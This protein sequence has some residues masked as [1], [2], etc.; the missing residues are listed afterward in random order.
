MHP[1][2]LLY[3]SVDIYRTAGH[4]I[5][6]TTGHRRFVFPIGIQIDARRDD[7]ERDEYDDEGFEIHGSA[8]FFNRFL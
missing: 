2:S 3:V 7:D 4:C 6:V 1:P 8:Y 5:Q